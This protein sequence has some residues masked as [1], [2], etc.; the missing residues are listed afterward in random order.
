MAANL[1]L[2]NGKVYTFDSAQPRAQAVALGF[3]RTLLV[4]DNETVLAEKGGHT[5]VI[6]LGGRT[7]IPGLVDAHLHFTGYAM[8]LAQVNLEGARSLEQAVA[9]V[10][11]R[12]QTASPGEWIRGHTWN[13]NDWAEPVFPDKRPLDAIAPSNPVVLS[14]KD[15]HSMWVN[16]AALRARNITRDTPDPAGGRIERDA[17]GEP[18]GLLF[19]DAIELMGAGIGVGQEEIPLPL[20]QRAISEAHQAG[21]TGIHN[22]EGANALRA[23]QALRASGTLTLRVVHF[24]PGAFLEPWAETG[25]EAGFG[26]DWLQMAGIKLFTDGALGSQTAALFDPFEGTENRGMLVASEDELYRSARSAAAHGF[27]VA[28]HAIGDRAIHIALN[29]LA[30]VRQEGFTRAVLRVEHA[31]HLAAADI[32]RFRQS[33]IVASMQPIH[34]PSDMFVADRLLGARGRYTYAFKSLLDSGATLWFGSDCPVETLDPMRGIHAAVT[35]QNERGEPT[36]GWYPEERLGVTQAVA[37]YYAPR[38]SQPPGQG[39]GALG[40]W[41]VLSDNIFEIPPA[42]ILNT[43]VEFTFAG[44]NMV[45][46][47]SA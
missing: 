37:A 40:D 2:A 44:G 3:G 41:V 15:G 10:A 4:G 13:H 47:D 45:Y 17:S 43:R 20:L 27:Q 29:A 16:S 46:P 24:F 25:V 12:I 32:P 23:F 35:R 36:N 34:Q 42:E 9:R 21:L 1:I 5:R 7:V 22:I 38:P 33:N 30:R 39:P 31:Q 14:R 26:D 19:E 18:T 11:T 28:I 8:G 6:D